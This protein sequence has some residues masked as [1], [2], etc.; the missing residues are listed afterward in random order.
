MLEPLRERH[1]KM[2]WDENTESPFSS[3]LRGV[4]CC[5]PSQQPESQGTKRI[6]TVKGKRSS[7]SCFRVLGFAVLFA[8]G[9]S[10]V[11]PAHLPGL[12]ANFTSTDLPWHSSWT[13]LLSSSLSITLL[14]HLLSCFYWTSN[15]LLVNMYSLPYLPTCLLSV[16]S[17]TMQDPKGRDSACVFH[18]CV[19][20]EL[21]WAGH[22]SP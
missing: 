21:D 15:N 6:I 8:H 7:L 17:T 4:R 13:G 20:R 14:T 2:G 12:S 18:C 22:S 9:F 16:P 3:W 10:W 11:F 5:P 1:N 19:S